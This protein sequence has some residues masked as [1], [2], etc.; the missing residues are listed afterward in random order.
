MKLKFNTRC[1]DK[2]TEQVY[3]VGDVVEFEENRGLEILQSSFASEVIE[4]SIEDS[5]NEP[6]EKKPRRKKK[7]A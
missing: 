4:A 3:E 6:E 7:D 1:V 5:T 2:H